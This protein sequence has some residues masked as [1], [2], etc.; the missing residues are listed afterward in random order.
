MVHGSNS[1]SNLF[2]YIKTYWNIATLTHL[3]TI[4]EDFHTTIAKLGGCD[5][6]YK[7]YNVYLLAP[8]GKVC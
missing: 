6:I 5:A 8:Y 2:L 1:V 7:A 3:S 4:C